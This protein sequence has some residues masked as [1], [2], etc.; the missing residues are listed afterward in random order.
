M[1]HKPEPKVL[2][3]VGMGRILTL[4][5]AV[6]LVGSGLA[7]NCRVCH[8]AG[9]YRECLRSAAAPCSVSMVNTTHLFLA[10]S[11]PTLRNATW[12]A[13]QP[14]QYQC[15]QVNYTSVAG[16]WSYEMGCTFTTTKICEGWRTASK[17]RTDTFNMIGVPTRRPAP[18]RADYNP[19]GVPLVILPHNTSYVVH[20]I[21]PV[22]PV[23]PPAVIVVH[24]NY[25]SAAGSVEFSTLLLLIIGVSIVRRLFIS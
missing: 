25:K 22:Q 8:S 24:R 19:Q 9:D 21:K 10:A 18:I 12:K 23:P 6:C 15:F 13:G 4:L 11:N 5:V 16:V 3:P 17:C 1:S 7:L 20:E 2:P 14:P